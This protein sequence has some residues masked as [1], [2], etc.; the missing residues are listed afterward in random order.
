VGERD[1]WLESGL[2][3]KEIRANTYDVNSLESEMYQW[4]VQKCLSNEQ[5]AINTFVLL[6][7]G[8]QAH[9]APSELPSLVLA[10]TGIVATVAGLPEFAPIAQLTAIL[11]TGMSTYNAMA[12]EAEGR[13]QSFMGAAMDFQSTLPTKQTSALTMVSEF[14]NSIRANYSEETLLHAY[15]FVTRLIGKSHS[16]RFAFNRYYNTFKRSAMPGPSLANYFV[17]NTEFDTG[18]VIERLLFSV[19]PQGIMACEVIQKFMEINGHCFNATT[20]GITVPGVGEF[21]VLITRTIAGSFGIPSIWSGWQ[22]SCSNLSV[23]AWQGYYNADRIYQTRSS[24]GDDW[25]Y[26]TSDDGHS[27]SRLEVQRGLSSDFVRLSCLGGVTEATQISGV[28][29]ASDSLCAQCYGNLGAQLGT[30]H[31]CSLAHSQ[32]L[33]LSRAAAVVV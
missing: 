24:L 19:S 32:K 17:R 9:A 8:S 25:M 2:I 18:E 14:V 26:W 29:Y 11:N 1:E 23:D 31:T 33:G 13:S 28:N 7:Q 27:P 30:D 22:Y 6:M 21:H 15:R 5:A 10:W 16:Y 20:P 4:W 3:A 12:K